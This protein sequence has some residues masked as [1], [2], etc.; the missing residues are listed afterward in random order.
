MVEAHYLSSKPGI[1]R[2]FKVWAL[3]LSGFILSGFRT[4]CPGSGPKPIIK[5]PQTLKKRPEK[6]G[7][8]TA[9]HGPART[10]NHRNVVGSE[11][12]Q[13]SGPET[14]IQFYGTS[15]PRL[16]KKEKRNRNGTLCCT[17]A[18]FS[19]LS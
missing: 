10:E 2:I 18:I 9:L 13:Q 17:R 4:I 14:D 19:P 1:V 8:S 11:T 3:N 6:T 5:G 16:I 12:A 15:R 7:V